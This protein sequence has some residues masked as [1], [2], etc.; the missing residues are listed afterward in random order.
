MKRC[1]LLV[2]CATL[3]FPAHAQLSAPVRNGDAVITVTGRSTTSQKVELSAWRMAET[4]HVT[5]FSQGDEARLRTA[6]HNLEKLHFLLSALLGRTDHPDDT[7]K[8]AVTMIGDAAEFEQL[9]LTDTR[10]QYGPFPQAFRKTT[11]YDP[12]EKG[13]VLAT[14]EEGVNLT[15][16]ASDGRPTKLDCSDKDSAAWDNF[17]VYRPDP[18]SLMKAGLGGDVDLAPDPIDVAAQLSKTKSSSVKVLSPASTPASHK[19]I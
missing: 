6:A 10:W 17:V 14:T 2:A 12:R 11:Y 5:V 19:T 13:S 16:Q 4:P 3:A 9:R 8:I 1:S 15:L 7:I 18:R